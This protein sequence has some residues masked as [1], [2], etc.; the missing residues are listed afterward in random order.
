[1]PLC[2]FCVSYISPEADDAVK[3]FHTCAHLYLSDD[4][5]GLFTKQPASPV[6]WA[7]SFSRGVFC[8]VFTW[9]FLSLASAIGMSV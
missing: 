2:Q 4:S 9:E 1:M 8:S 3:S 6:I 7:R 5:E